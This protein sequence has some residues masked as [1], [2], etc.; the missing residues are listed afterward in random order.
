MA[1]KSQP[2]GG[3]SAQPRGP[4][5]RIETQIHRRKK[6][7]KIPPLES[8]WDDE[9]GK[10]PPHLRMPPGNMDRNPKPKSSAAGPR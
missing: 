8:E 9:Q 1:E 7:R 6:A 10:P 2:P 4:K 5:P 3:E